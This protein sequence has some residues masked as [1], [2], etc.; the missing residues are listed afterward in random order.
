MMTNWQVKPPQSFHNLENNA[1]RKRV[2]A[3]ARAKKPKLIEEEKG[4]AV[5]A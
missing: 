2:T 4:F 3:T 5:E 1:L